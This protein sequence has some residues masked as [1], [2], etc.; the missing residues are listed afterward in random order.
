MHPEGSN[1]QISS[2]SSS[3][4][5]GRLFL[6]CDV[7]KSSGFTEQAFCLHLYLCTM[8]MQ[9]SRRADNKDIGSHGT[10]VTDSSESPS[11][12]LTTWT[13]PAAA[14]FTRH[15]DVLSNTQKGR[16]SLA[17]PTLSVSQSIVIEQRD[18]ATFYCDSKVENIT[19]H[20]ISNNSSLVLNERM[21]LSADHKTLTIL[22]VQREDSGS[23]QCEVR[24][25]AEGQSSD[26][27]ILSVNYGP[28]PVAIKLDSGVTTGDTVEV[29]EGHTVNFWVETQSHPAPVYTWYLPT[30][31]IQT[32]T[33]GTFTI[34]AVS[35]E[36]AGMYRCLVSNSVTQ[37]SR[38]G[39]VEVQVLEK[40]TAPSIE[41][42]TLALVENATSVTLTCKTSHQGAGVRWFLRG[43]LLRPSDHLT[44][45]PQ[46]RTLTI[47]GLQRDD[48]GPYECEVWHWGSRARSTPLRLTINYGPDRVDITPGS[49]SE[50]VS[51]IEA[52]VNSSLTLH[53]RT[54]SKPDARYHWTHE[55]SSEVHTGERLSLE[56]LSREH[57]GIYSCTAFND[58]TGLA[59]SASVL[60][61][62]VGKP[63]Y[64]NMVKPQGEARGKEV[65]L[66]I[67]MELFMKFFRWQRSLRTE[68][69]EGTGGCINNSIALCQRTSFANSSAPFSISSSAVSASKHSFTR[70]QIVLD[71]HLSSRS[72]Y[73]P[74]TAPRHDPDQQE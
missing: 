54:D 8:C 69:I 5:R 26:I 52:M 39:V 3:Y 30:D 70:A 15:A 17:K 56:A 21:K 72:P 45:S 16:A 24:H 68:G 73:G 23:Y 35:R 28:D 59:Q 58:V 66:R 46:N 25:G 61:K 33:T 37:L 57:E 11:S 36:H 18:V 20:W 47:H 34:Q 67:N 43:Q 48:T 53:C 32:P 42:P 65:G 2:S 4:H 62:V 12:L 49:A 19:I 14:Q 40:L 9:Y 71:S 31:F 50:V 6:S 64:D 27:T 51:T 1:S 41:F 13:S 7:N 10:G 63:V 29:M 55:H 44:L 38:L 74:P 60:I 22:I